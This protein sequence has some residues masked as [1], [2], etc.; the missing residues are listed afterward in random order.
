MSKFQNIDVLGL[1]GYTPVALITDEEIWEQLVTAQVKALLGDIQG[2]VVSVKET[3][4]GRFAGDETSNLNDHKLYGGK[5]GYVRYPF[6]ESFYKT[7]YGAFQVK[8]DGLKVKAFCWFGDTEKGTPDL[9]LK[10]ALRDRRFDGAKRAND[11]ALLD[12][13][14]DDPKYN[15]KLG[16]VVEGVVENASSC[17]LSAY[18]FMP[19][20]RIVEACGDLE[21]DQFVEKPYTFL[22]RPELFL[23]LFWRAWKTKR[24]PGQNGNPVPDVSKHVA[25]AFEKLAA[26][27]GYDYLENAPSHFH[28]AKWT[29]ANGYL[30]CDTKHAAALKALTDGIKKLKAGGMKLTRSQESWVCV[31]QSLPKEHRPKELDLDGPIWPQDNIGQEN[32]WMWKP[33]SERAKRAHAEKK[34]SK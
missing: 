21:F 34:D 11:T 18:T 25:M 29:E 14:Y 4:A 7:A 28:V 2:G 23:K 16:D 3:T 8:R 24:G 26:S 15:A 19:G 1:L 27:K 32:L 10:L 9:I 31:I 17:E 13:P 33:I 30:Y 6:V 5:D 22:D 12:Y 20:S